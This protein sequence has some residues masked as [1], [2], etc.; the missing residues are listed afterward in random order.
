MEV[1]PIT[2]DELHNITRNP[3]RKSNKRRV[4]RLDIE[5]DIVEIISVYDISK[6]TIRYLSEPQPIILSDLPEGLTINKLS[7]E[8][9]CKLNPAIHRMILEMAVNLA[10]K[11]RASA[12]K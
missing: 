7:K 12:G 9:K 8:T 3:F 6:Y 4:L 10:L 1:V 11:S 2:Q 5:G